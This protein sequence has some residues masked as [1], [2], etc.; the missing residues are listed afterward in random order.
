M[1]QGSAERLLVDDGIADVVHARFAYFFGP[2]AEAGLAEVQRIL[3]PG[4]IFL[5]IDN[6]WSGGDFARLLRAS[7]V[8]NAAIDPDEV[9]HW[10][11]EQ[12]AQR[13]DVEGAWIAAST[14]ELDKILRLEFPSEVV[15]DF[16]TNHHQAKLTYHFALYEWRPPE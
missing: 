11:V 14:E 8:G 6:S 10:W 4:G 16:M 2:G 7:T 13:H 3:A 1:H 5:A 15:D 9:H 12:G